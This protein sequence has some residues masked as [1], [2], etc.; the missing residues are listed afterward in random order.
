MK[1]SL[2]TISISS[3][4]NPIGD[5]CIFTDVLNFTEGTL[6]VLSKTSFSS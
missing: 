3:I 2:M 6:R 5:R 1:R 4:V